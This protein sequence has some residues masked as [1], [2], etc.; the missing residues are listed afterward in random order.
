MV[1][2]CGAEL[3]V[4]RLPSLPSPS[5]SPYHVAVAG[6]H[7]MSRP[8][9]AADFPPP[10]SNAADTGGAGAARMQSRKRAR[11]RGEAIGG[12]GWVGYWFLGA[13]FFPGCAAPAPLPL[14][15]SLEW[16]YC[17]CCESWWYFGRLLSGSLSFMASRKSPATV[18]LSV[19]AH[20]TTEPEV[21]C[22]LCSQASQEP[23]QIGNTGMG[24]RAVR[25]GLPHRNNGG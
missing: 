9:S 16:W 6:R 3:R 24:G 5:A 12:L 10:K 4:E 23:V 22:W 15:D 25:S 17:G 18:S 7:S 2:W 11:E 13:P 14:L 20:H 21:L 8:A 19:R 1:C